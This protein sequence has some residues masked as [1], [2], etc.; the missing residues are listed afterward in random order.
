M[1]IA[2]IAGRSA[3]IAEDQIDQGVTED[4]LPE[5]RPDGVE[6]YGPPY[7]APEACDSDYA[8]CV[9]DG[10]DPDAELQKQQQQEIRL[11]QLQPPTTTKTPAK[12]NALAALPDLDDPPRG[13]AFPMAEPYAARAQE[14]DEHATTVNHYLD[15]LRVANHQLRDA[16]RKLGAQAQKY[17]R[18]LDD[19]SAKMA[20]SS[21]RD[22]G[23]GKLEKLDR[24]MGGQLTDR[25]AAYHDARA[26]MRSAADR[27]RAADA[28][29]REALAG[30][31]ISGREV[32]LRTLQDR[33][34]ALA[35]EQERLKG[36]GE[37]REGVSSK[38]GKAGLE[39]ANEEGGEAAA[40][41]A[42]VVVGFGTRVVNDAELGRIKAAREIIQERMANEKDGL[43]KAKLAK[44]L[45]AL[46]KAEKERS[47]AAKD[48][49][50]AYGKAWTQ[51][52]WLAKHEQGTTMFREAARSFGRM[53]KEGHDVMS[54]AASVRDLTTTS[55]YNQLTEM[56]E[57]VDHDLA[58]GTA[59]VAADGDL[60]SD[61][62]T[63]WATSYEETS[64]YLGGATQG[65]AR[66]YAKTDRVV[67]AMEAG[68]QFAP[69]DRAMEASRN[70]LG[71]AQTD[72]VKQPADGR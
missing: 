20:Q 22:L 38:G 14:L 39:A 50:T 13:P 5:K 57:L 8:D 32:S 46:D 42:E 45:D 11:R 31:E 3:E 70:E 29:V 1:D 47:A 6:V 4:A 66:E 35:E 2:G 40:D 24:A 37:G 51:V 28:G 18:A 61:A 49:V 7:E 33:D 16:D 48:Y 72:D 54:E 43:E 26:D 58:N 56:H 67:L 62:F 41:L 69:I 15:A 71:D 64:R 27:V 34:A 52:N 10:V 30:V 65:L 25:L 68:D 9:P 44:A 21:A 59:D 23:K 19:V 53:A 17:G 63:S 36:R 55:P 12:T 60:L